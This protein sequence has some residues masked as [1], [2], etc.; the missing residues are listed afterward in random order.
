MFSAIIGLASL[1]LS[2]PIPGVPPDALDVP[3]FSL[4]QKLP[5][6]L[7][8]NNTTVE[9]AVYDETPLMNV[10]FEKTDWPNVYFKAPEGTWDWSGTLGIAVDV[11]NPESTPIPVAMRIDNADADGLHNCVTVNGMARPGQ[12][13]AFFAPL[14]S[15]EIDRYWGMRGIPVFGPIG[16]GKRIDPSQITGFQLFLPRPEQPHRLFL[17]NFRLIQA[18]SPA[19]EAVAF[20][21]IDT[22][23]QFKHADWPG[24]LHNAQE[25]PQRIEAE[26]R[27][28]AF[29]MPEWDEFGGWAA[30]PRREAT[31]WFR[32]EQID[33][34]WWLVTPTG[35]LF[36]STGIDCVG[37]WSLT[38]VEG[39]DGWFEGLPTENDPWFGPCYQ[40]VA[41]AHSGAEVIGGTGK[42]FG[43]Y[44]ANLIRKYGN[45]WEERWRD[46]SYARLKSWGFNT[47]GNWSQGDVLD[48][49][50]LPFVVNGGVQNVLRVEGGG[51]YWAKMTDPYDPAFPDQVETSLRGVFDAHKDNPRCIGYFVDNELA[52]EAVERGPLASP[53]EQPC[54]KAQIAMLA[55][56]Y[57]T[58]DA[59]NAAWNTTAADWDALRAPESPNAACAADLQE[60]VRAF[61]LRYF[62]TVN[63]VLKRHAPH[64]LYLGCRFSSAPRTVVEAAGDVCDVV[65]FN[66]YQTRI[67]CARYTGDNALDAPIIIG[68]FHFGALDRG[69]FHTGLVPTAS[70]EARAQSYVDYVRSVADCPAFV[71]CHWFQYVDEPTTGRWFDGENYNIGFV[72]VVDSPYPEMVA[73]AR[74]V[75]AEIYRRRFEGVR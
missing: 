39:R 31:G 37:T 23:G 15:A 71:G 5:D 33:G 60:F 52:W 30:G 70:Q 65:S 38:F 42:A 25:W 51:G 9:L 50:P 56:K 46:T 24:K 1:A 10:A 63:G 73:A 58:I 6:F 61:A 66:I 11:Y 4:E 55:D 32:T 44:K 16:T 12:W 67:D 43:F 22:F 40:Q 53:P 59:L 3:L 17:S 2:T 72:T 19:G 54:R 28:H 29:E 57:R 47:I 18:S 35:R 45:Q 14:P 7:V 64:Q 13:I 69:M 20:P 8:R 27:E 49:S 41:N 36:F 74:Q 68:E 48:N 75:H 26:A 62:N 21:F 34:A